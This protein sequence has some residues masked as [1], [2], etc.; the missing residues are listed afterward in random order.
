MR[1][2][3]RTVMASFQGLQCQVPVSASKKRL[4]PSV[5]T[6]SATGRILACV[7]LRWLKALRVTLQS[8]TLNFF[9]FSLYE[10]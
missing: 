9:M 10:L 2:V 8:S 5:F 6:F 1:L 4:R 7:N 3:A